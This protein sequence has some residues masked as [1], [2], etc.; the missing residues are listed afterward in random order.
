MTHINWSAL[1]T[2]MTKNG[3]VAHAIASFNSFEGFNEVLFGLKKGFPECFSSTPFGKA[4][5]ISLLKAHCLKEWMAQ[6]QSRWESAR[7]NFG[8]SIAG[9][10]FVPQ[11]ERCDYK[12]VLYDTCQTFGVP[13]IELALNDE[14][15]KGSDLP[16]IPDDRWENLKTGDRIEYEGQSYIVVENMGNNPGGSA[17]L[18]LAPAEAI[19]LNA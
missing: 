11:P 7:Q 13:Y 9:T 12:L 17:Y 10:K 8:E 4:V 19:D 16:K 18:S 1:K 15:V 14:T 3:H 5:P 2:L 6:E